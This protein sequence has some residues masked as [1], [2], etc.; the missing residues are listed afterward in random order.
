MMPVCTC[1]F[2]ALK[3]RENISP[4]NVAIY[5][6]FNGP[7]FTA[8]ITGPIR[9]RVIIVCTFT[10]TATQVWQTD[11][12]TSHEQYCSYYY[13]LLFLIFIT[14]DG[15]FNKWSRIM[16]EDRIADLPPLPAVNRFVRSSAHVTY[17]SLDHRG[18]PSKRHLDRFSQFYRE[19][20][21]DQQTDRQTDRPRY[22]VCSRP[23]SLDITAMRPENG[24][25]TFIFYFSPKK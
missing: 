25:W 19:H 5:V 17:G 23:Q 11:I 1:V 4:Q 9:A 14:S 7:R 15:K 20:K 16:M 21:L 18:Q 13:L 8:S 3:N 6:L 22:S 12:D 24:M 10:D 2:I